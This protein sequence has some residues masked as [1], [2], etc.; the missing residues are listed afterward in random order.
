[1]YPTQSTAS[2]EYEFNIS[3]IL[4]GDYPPAFLVEVALR[5]TLAFVAAL[6]LFRLIGKRNV[7]QISA[8]DLVIIIAMGSAVG[9]PMIYADV[10]IVPAL[11]SV[12]V[13]V[14]MNYGLARA[15]RRRRRLEAFIESSA[16]LVV[17]R[18]QVI[19]SALDSESLSIYEL[20]ELLRLA[21]IERVSDV[22][23]A[24]FEPSGRLSVLR[25]GVDP[26]TADVW[27]EV[28]EQRADGSS[29]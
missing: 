13:V 2:S 20:H 26:V 22:E 9:D 24:S 14:A 23:A 8:F 5:S 6:L 21:G 28:L 10:P 4:V 18:G 29:D 16:R 3:R 15:T 11:L 7:S 27:T 25:V 19:D 1:M 17:H 12:T